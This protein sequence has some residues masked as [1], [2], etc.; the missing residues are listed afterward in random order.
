MTTA[1]DLIKASYRKI[2]ILGQG[3]TLTAEEANDAFSELNAMLAQF[4]TQGALI[5]TETKET[6]SLTGAASYTIGSGGDF[7][8]SLPKNIIAAYATYSGLDY[9]LSIIDR[10]EYSFIADKDLTGT[11][12]K[13]YFDSN[14]P[15]G[16][17]YL[18]PLNYSSTTLTLLSEKPLTSF[19]TLDTV[20]AM[21]P[22][23]E[24]MLVHNLAVRMAPEYER[25]ASPTVKRIARES[26]DHIKAQNKKN[27]KNKVQIDSAYLNDNS[28]N[29]NSGTYL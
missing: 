7:N 11:P 1:R 16:T 12:Y 26:L 4:S 13:L 21:P 19:T 2:S 27:N 24:T 25:E 9:P 10:N 22:E 6:F 17:I 15:L 20:F 14:Y 29:I 3:S 8:T 28:F 18:W 5:Y 23:Y